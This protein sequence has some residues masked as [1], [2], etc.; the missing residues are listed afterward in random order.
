M[1]SG[2]HYEVQ[3]ESEPIELYKLL[4]IADLVSGGGEAKIVISE[5]YVYLNGEVETQKR[6]K[7]YN[8]DVIEFNGDVL[9]LTVANIS[10]QAAPKQKATPKKRKPINF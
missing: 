7:I 5:G 6:K 8:G 3:L 2:N 10:P 9:T 4:K 1:E